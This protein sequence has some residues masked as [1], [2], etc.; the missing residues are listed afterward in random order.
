M[1]GAADSQYGKG[2]PYGKKTKR[3]V[4]P[5]TERVKTVLE[6]HLAS[7]NTFGIPVRTIQYTVKQA[8]TSPAPQDRVVDWR[9]SEQWTT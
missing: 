4:M 5:M 1:A 7:E 2:G 3:P 6:H 8:T 9:G